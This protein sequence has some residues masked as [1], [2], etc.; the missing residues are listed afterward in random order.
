MPPSGGA[1]LMPPSAL[2]DDEQTFGRALR[3]AITA[4]GMSVNAFARAY[5]PP[6]APDSRV[7]N[8]A[9][10]VRRWMRGANVPSR[11]SVR[12]CEDVLSLPPGTLERLA[13][14]P[15]QR[16]IQ[17]QLADIHVL[18]ERI[19]LRLDQRDEVTGRR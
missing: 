5:E 19:Q 4:A 12:R 15:G 18:L 17:E 2:V 14:R 3:D 13:R 1:R 9:G 8:R 16:S 11:V 7:K 10:A 6:D